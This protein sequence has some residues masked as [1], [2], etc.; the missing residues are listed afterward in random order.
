MKKKVKKL[1]KSYQLLTNCLESLKTVNELVFSI[2]MTLFYHDLVMIDENI[3]TAILYL[4]SVPPI[5]R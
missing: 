2:K 5:V 3:S 1:R 4:L